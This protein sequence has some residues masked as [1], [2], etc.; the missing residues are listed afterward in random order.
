[1]TINPFTVAIVDDYLIIRKSI[2]AFLSYA[3]LTVFLEAEHGKDLIAQLQVATS[4]PDICLL[5]INMPVMDGFDTACYLKEYYPSIK[6]MAF[7]TVYNRQRLARI[8]ECGVDDHMSKDATP[9]EL[10]SS[11]IKLHEKDSCQ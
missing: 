8:K 5:D 2:K 4:L 10:L 11:L 1:M 3:G 7:S 6:I 9:D